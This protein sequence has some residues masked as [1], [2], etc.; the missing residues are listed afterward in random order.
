MLKLLYLIRYIGYVEATVENIS[1]FMIDGLDVDKRASKDRVMNPSPAR[2]TRTTWRAGRYLQL[3][4]PTREQRNR[5]GDCTDP[6]R[7]REGD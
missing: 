2:N 5:T 4:L 1:I 6:D 7:Q 3:P